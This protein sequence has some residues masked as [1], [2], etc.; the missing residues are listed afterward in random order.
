MQHRV[1]L[2]SKR[3]IEYIRRVHSMTPSSRIACGCGRP[4][5]RSGWMLR[6]AWNEIIDWFDWFIDKLLKKSSI[7]PSTSKLPGLRG[8]RGTA[9]STYDRSVREILNVA[10]FDKSSA[11]SSDFVPDCSSAS[12]SAFVKVSATGAFGFSV[13]FCKINDV[14]FK[15]NAKNN[16]THS[17]SQIHQ[18]RKI[19][20]QQKY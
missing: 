4:F 1:K 2:T 13:S 10:L 18:T 6:I 3:S 16:M 5:H 19:V 20:N 11:E 9:G 8:G 15:K 17:V 12:N 14:H 7:F